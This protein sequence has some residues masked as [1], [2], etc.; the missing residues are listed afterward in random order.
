M[1]FS[2]AIAALNA[3]RDGMKYRL[4]TKEAPEKTT[5]LS[6]RLF[7]VFHYLFHFGLLIF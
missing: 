6:H 2:I 4:N 5:Y 3:D 1:S 7:N